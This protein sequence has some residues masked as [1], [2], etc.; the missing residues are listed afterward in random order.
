MFCSGKSRIGTFSCPRLA[1]DAGDRDPTDHVSIPLRASGVNLGILNLAYRSRMLPLDRTRMALLRVVARMLSLALACSRLR[2]GE[3]ERERLRA[4]MESIAGEQRRLLAIIE[5]TPDI[6]GIADAAGRVLYFNRA[7]RRLLGV[8]DDDEVAAL[9]IPDT[10]PSWASRLVMGEGL[11][12]AAR[13]GVW[14]GETA[15]LTRDGREIPTLQVIVAHKNEAGAVEYYSTIARDITERKQMEEKLNYLASRDPL[16]GLLNRVKFQEELEAEIARAKETGTHGALLFFNVDNFK[17]INDTLGYQAGDA[18]LRRVAGVLASRLRECDRAARFAGDEFALLLPRTSLEEARRIGNQMLAL[19]RNQ[20]FRLEGRLIRL[21]VSA[22]L[23]CYP[24]EAE[25]AEDLL[26]N[27][28]VAVYAAKQAGGG[29]VASYSDPGVGQGR[30]R[31][32]YRLVWEHNIREALQKDGFIL[33]WQPILDLRE[34]QVAGYELL[35]RMKGE[36]GDI[37]GPQQ[38]L[39]IAEQSNLIQAIDRWVVRRAVAMLSRLTCPRTGRWRLH[40]NASGRSFADGELVSLVREAT[41]QYR[42]DPSRLVFE[43]TETAAIADLHRARGFIDQ[44]RG[45]GCGFALDD[46]GVGF[47]TFDSLRRLPVDFLKIDGSFIQ[48]LAED[49]G[50]QHVVRAMVAAARGLG[51]KTIAEFISDER[52]LEIVAGFGVDFGQG[53]HIGRP[54][55]CPLQQFP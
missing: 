27:A 5:D 18:L 26:I 17:G 7:A 15:F 55:M 24:S 9:R 8:E 6:V 4:M 42:V 46:F 11:P 13:E 10:H 21:E 54:E 14:R 49:E 40:V 41:E 12:I 43:L 35:L 30:R 34:R 39:P 51:Q 52:T 1:V 29:Q 22:G 28:D 45:M 3:K 53:Y 33:Y 19:L 48:G 47:S 23:A 32:A 44:L 20:T 38:F 50:K 31:V 36:D 16:T 25:T 2:S 37:I